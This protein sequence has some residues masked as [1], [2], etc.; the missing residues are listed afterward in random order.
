MVIMSRI[1]KEQS[2]KEYKTLFIGP[3]LAKKIE[4]QQT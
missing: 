2:G 4:A 3:C 1:T